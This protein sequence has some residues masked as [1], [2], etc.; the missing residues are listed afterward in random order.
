MKTGFVKLKEES[1]SDKMKNKNRIKTKQN[2]WQQIIK[3]LALFF[4]NND[5]NVK[6][7]GSVYDNHMFNRLVG[8]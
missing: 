6:N 1:F 2:K 3:L 7:Y 5:K 8:C 4:S